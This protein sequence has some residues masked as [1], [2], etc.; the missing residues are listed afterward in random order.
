MRVS[1]EEFVKRILPLF[2]EPKP[3]HN[4]P[5]SAKPEELLEDDYDMIREAGMI[6][7]NEA[8]LRQAIQSFPWKG[9]PARGVPIEEIQEQFEKI[10]AWFKKIR[11]ILGETSER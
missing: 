11:E 7:V 5:L 3:I 9:I 6:L 1:K 8:E 4:D 2:L 10:R